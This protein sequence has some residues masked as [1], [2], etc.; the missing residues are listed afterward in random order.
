MKVIIRQGPKLVQAQLNERDFESLAI[1]L[2]GALLAKHKYMSCQS[3]ARNL[4][5]IEALMMEAAIQA[6][7]K[8][9]FSP[10]KRKTVG[11]K[12]I[13]ARMKGG[14]LLEQTIWNLIMSLDGNG[15]LHG[16]GFEGARGNAEKISLTEL[17]QPMFN[18]LNI[19]QKEKH[20]MEMK[21]EVIVAA[22]NLL[23]ASGLA[24]FKVDAETDEETMVRQFMA[25]VES[26]PEAEEDNVPDEVGDV[27][28]ALR[29]EEDA[30]TLGFDRTA[31]VEEKKA[32]GKS[33][34]TKTE[35]KAAAPKA[36]EE[37][38][39]KATGKATTAKKPDPPKEKAGK[40]APPV[41]EKNFIGHVVGS[42]AD[43]IDQALVKGATKEE[44]VKMIMKDF[45]RDE[46]LAKNKV[47]GDLKN[48][49]KQWGTPVH[50]DEKT[51]KYSIKVK[52]G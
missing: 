36:K 31:P 13:L 52:K 24:A 11:F 45:G 43:A 19:Q 33:A 16:F 39:A 9:K 51:K 7:A 1:V 32:K 25:A 6:H 40:K 21:K 46:T 26:I 42:M 30:G 47:E 10:V 20:T 23:N 37:P 41:R 34:K 2:V 28:N 15:N 18:T 50:F 27:F 22:I 5:I 35:T 48:L 49:P 4:G 14:R 3:A 44:M 29:D 17:K 12:K 8:S 38:K